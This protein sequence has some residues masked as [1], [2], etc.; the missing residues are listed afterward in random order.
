MQKR[1]RAERKLPHE[2][3]QVENGVQLER[4]RDQDLGAAAV[5]LRLLEIAGEFQGD[6]HLRREGASAANIFVTD[7]RDFDAIEHAKHAQHFAVGPKQRA[8]PAVA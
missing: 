3:G 1:G 6:G 2:I 7:G 8:P 4:Q 5:L